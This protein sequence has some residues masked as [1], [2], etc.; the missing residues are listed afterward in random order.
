MTLYLASGF[1]SACM[2]AAVARLYRISSEE[3]RPG[4]VSPPKVHVTP[5]REIY[6][7]S[8]VALANSHGYSEC[9]IDSLTTAPTPHQ[10]MFPP[11]QKISKS[12]DKS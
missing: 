3:G 8:S 12:P 9:S 7:N 2:L 4:Y 1:T 5:P 10:A 6:K 11:Q